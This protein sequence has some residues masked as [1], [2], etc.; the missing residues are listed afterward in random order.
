M[1]RTGP[2]PRVE[3]SLKGCSYIPA[4][5]DRTR[6]TRNLQHFSSNCI[7]IIILIDETMIVD[8]QKIENFDSEAIVVREK[9]NSFREISKKLPRKD[10]SSIFF[11]PIVLLLLF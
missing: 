9:R 5:D 8:S 1:P 4:L 11:L 6:G 10:A 3:T 2:P 7:I